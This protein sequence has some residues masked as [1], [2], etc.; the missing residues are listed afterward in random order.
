VV[1]LHPGTVSRSLTATRDAG[2]GCEST[3]GART[4]LTR[5]FQSHFKQGL[6]PAKSCIREANELSALR[7][8]RK[9]MDDLVHE[10]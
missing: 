10:N 7:E 3:D 8:P 4:R 5:T 2:H 9:L 1:A 6:C